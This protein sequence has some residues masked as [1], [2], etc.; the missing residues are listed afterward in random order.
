L[1]N[2]WST[3]FNVEDLNSSYRGDLDPEKIVW[4]QIQRCNV[5]HSQG[6][7][8]L[9]GNAVLS[10]L[11]NVPEDIRLEVE[12]HEE[13]YHI[14]KKQWVPQ[15]RFSGD[16]EAPFI[17]NNRGDLDYDAAYR[18]RRYEK[19]GDGWK[20]VYET[21]GIHQVSPI[22]T[23]T[24]NWDYYVLQKLIMA[25][26]QNHGLTWKKERTEIF[27]GEEW[28]PA[29]DPPDDEEEEGDVKLEV[30]EEDVGVKPAAD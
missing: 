1:S 3:S 26:L 16:P 12:D 8:I 2:P 11:I 13:E 14:V 15:G 29:F 5:L 27:T 9:Y 24:E 20:E 28:D 6:D 22:W 21:G 17:I 4:L 25:A 30:D 19:D 23:E 10:L 18:G 7:E